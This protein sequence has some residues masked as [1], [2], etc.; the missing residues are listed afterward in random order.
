MSQAKLTLRP[1]PNI[2][3]V[4]GYPGI[5]PGGSR[6]EAAVKGAIEVRVG[7]QGVKAK[8]VRIELRRVETLPGG[9]LSNTFYDFVGHSPINVWQ[10]RD[11]YS[12]LENQDFPFYI[13]I[14]ESI[15]PSIAL[16]KGAGIKYELIATVCVKGKR[17]LL[18][19]DKSTVTSASSTIIIDKHELHPTWPVY[20]QHETRQHAE[21]GVTLTVDRSHTCYGPGDRIV[22]MA[23]VKAQP[24]QTHMLRGFEFALRETTVFRASPHTTGKKGAPQVKVNNISERKVPVNVTL[25][26]GTQHKAELTVTVPPHHTSATL[27]AARHIDIMYV[28]QVKAL[29]GTGQSVTLDLPVVVSNWPRSV[30]LEAMRRIGPA[31]NVS[32][33]G[34]AGADRLLKPTTPPSS[35][36]TQSKVRPDTQASTQSGASHPPLAQPH[37]YSAVDADAMP[38]R[39]PVGQSN[40]APMERTNGF[41]GSNKPDE[42]GVN[43]TTEPAK[44][45]SVHQASSAESSSY[46]GAQANNY[47]V[48]TIGGT[49]AVASGSMNAAR[50]MSQFA[51]DSVTAARPRLGSARAQ[52]ASNRLTVANLN[53]H[54]AEEYAKAEREH[55]GRA[56]RAPST[57]PGWI[58][59]EE[60]KQRLYETAVANVE[61]IQGI[62]RPRSPTSSTDSP[63]QTTSMASPKLKS[64]PWPTAEEEKARLFHQ[65][66]AAV[67]RTQGLSSSGGIS[68]PSSTHGHGDSLTRSESAVST[69]ARDSSNGAGSSS[70]QPPQRTPIKSPTPQYPSAEEE[71]A[72]LKRYHEAKAAVERTQGVTY[73]MSSQSPPAVP[74]PYDALYPSTPVSPPPPAL[75]A[76][77]LPPAFIP[78]SSQPSYLSEKEKL[79]RAY[80]AQDAA[81]VAN[82]A[83]LGAVGSPQLSPLAA[84]DSYAS[85]PPL[86]A[87][88]ASSTSLSSAAAEKEMLRRRFET[89]DAAALAAA[90]PPAPPPR[91]N[92]IR[93][94]PSPPSSGSRPI[95]TPPQSPGMA[96]GSR[97]MT[98]AEE[99]ARLKAM[100]EAEERAGQPNG[101][102]SAPLSPPLPTNDVN[103]NGS[104]LQEPSTPPPPLPPLM[105]RPPKQYIEETQEEDK[106][107]YARL[108]A[109]DK[110]KPGL[111]G[112]LKTELILSS[113]SADLID[114]NGN[115]IP[116]P[117]P[118]PPLP[119]KPVE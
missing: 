88:P 80:E 40:T 13:R 31:P 1:P 117:G 50:V 81:A 59:A 45:L 48:Q 97:P 100:Y 110:E 32:L 102:V 72:A 95:P 42:F 71:K 105:P 62:S 4:Q 49:Q 64:T 24:L 58:S 76:D 27:N 68:P 37:P 17:G 39:S 34:P 96:G 3:F 75:V 15:P 21:D 47:A 86:A 61:R 116:T 89:Q 60:E 57:R 63:S 41:A 23:T 29:L 36:T 84:F 111:T 14:P 98:A 67:A 53:D 38:V 113:F 25:Y 11:E 16:E 54:E 22:V 91:S 69:L 101:I 2:D 92:G 55:A 74:I 43:R 94:S 26:G 83:R 65:A 35:E 30:S 107:T 18:R 104:L 109:M 8:W 103:M 82:A 66:Q 90:G 119:P 73:G 9:G 106:R 99:K 46:G 12:M 87:L 7:P 85:S 70:L 28:L 78:S 118:P 10:A 108:E 6:P 33:P 56:T 52:S 79:R 112:S 77:D 114:S 51:N 19:R 5:P 20:S 115:T 93:P 44:G